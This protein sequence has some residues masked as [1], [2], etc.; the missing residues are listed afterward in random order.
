MWV[1]IGPEM[2]N[3]NV[4][5]INVLVEYFQYAGIYS[6]MKEIYFQFIS[7]HKATQLEI[8]SLMVEC[9]EFEADLGPNQPCSVRHIV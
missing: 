2:F 7:C 9:I 4:A 6:S 1:C 8:N 5:L 3:S